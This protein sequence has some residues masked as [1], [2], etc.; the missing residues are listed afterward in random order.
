[1]SRMIEIDKIDL[2]NALGALIMNTS[3]DYSMKT[4]E[5]LNAVSYTVRTSNGIS[6][7]ICSVEE[8]IELTIGETML[9]KEQ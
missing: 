1:M 3:S 6:V 7:H 4:S 2:A 5:E 9:P 8:Y